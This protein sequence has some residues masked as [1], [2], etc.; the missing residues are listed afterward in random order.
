MAKVATDFEKIIQ[1]G[2]QHLPDSPPSTIPLTFSSLQ[3]RERKKNEALA[4]RI[5]SKNRRQSAPSKLKA[6]PGP[7][8][9]SRVGVKKVDTPKYTK[10]I[11]KTNTYSNATPTSASGPINRLPEM[12][13]A[14]GL[15]IY[16]TLSRAT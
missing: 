3:G 8:L 11:V 1:E 12:S 10:R 16:T 9:A 7:S 6:T 14:N 13:T 5:F 15:T 2:K 4:D